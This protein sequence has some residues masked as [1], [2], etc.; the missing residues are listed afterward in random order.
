M[1]GKYTAVFAFL[2]VFTLFSPVADGYS[3]TVFGPQDL[4]VSRWHSHLSRHTFALESS[5]DGVIEVFKN[6]PQQEK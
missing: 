5:G 3:T 4:T 6:T 1:P 2:L